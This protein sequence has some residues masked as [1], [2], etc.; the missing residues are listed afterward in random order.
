[1]FLA[2]TYQSKW[3]NEWAREWFYMK[4]DLNERTDIKGIIQ[5]PI[6][7]CFG[8]KNQHVISTLKLR[9]L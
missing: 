5:T 1:M 7:T 9:L 4:N 8:Y 3:L 2:P 6:V